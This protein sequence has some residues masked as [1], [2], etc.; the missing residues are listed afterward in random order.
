MSEARL[1]ALSHHMY[2]TI[3][4]LAKK[5]VVFGV[6]LSGLLTFGST[7]I[8]GGDF[9]LAGCVLTLSAIWGV[10]LWLDSDFLTKKKPIRP[11]P[12]I[13]DYEEQLKRFQRRRIEYHSSQVGGAASVVVL[14]F[15]LFAFMH[16]K[17]EQKELDSLNGRLFPANEPA[18]QILCLKE[19]PPNNAIKVFFGPAVAVLS[20][21][22]QT[23]ISADGVPRLGIVKNSDGSIGINAHV[24]S[25]D[26]RIIAEVKNS[27]FIVNPNNYLRMKRKDR[28]SLSLLDQFGKTV[29]DVRYLNPSAVLISAFVVYTRAGD[30]VELAPLTMAA[31]MCFGDQD[32]PN[33]GDLDFS[34]S[35]PS[36]HLTN[37]ATPIQLNYPPVPGTELKTPKTSAPAKTAHPPTYPLTITPEIRV[38]T[39]PESPYEVQLVIAT[40]TELPGLNSLV[41]RFDGNIT[42]WSWTSP[43]RNTTKVTGVNAPSFTFP[44]AELKYGLKP[45]FNP[46]HPLVFL[47]WSK[48]QVECTK[49]DTF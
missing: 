16:G 11:R 3:L 29:L 10:A 21:F 23:V 15:G 36:N 2:R 35:N 26:G 46:A 14:L 43:D 48:E 17:W 28:S 38:S 33:K 41:L 27:Q 24:V 32:D 39:D 25:I 44:F 13:R 42:A 49:V 9:W 1:V 6:G 18:P 45:E 22:P 7:M 20:K 4:T 37:N 31:Q 40:T 8:Y 19:Q 34:R 12:R 47:V 30:M 5:P